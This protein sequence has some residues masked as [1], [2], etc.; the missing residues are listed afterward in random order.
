MN[1]KHFSLVSAD[2]DVGNELELLRNILL[3]QVENTY[4]FLKRLPAPTVYALVRSSLRCSSPDGWR[5][6]VNNPHYLFVRWK[7][8]CISPLEYPILD[9]IDPKFFILILKSLPFDTIYESITSDGNTL[10]TEQKGRELSLSISR[11][12]KNYPGLFYGLNPFIETLLFQI[13]N[14]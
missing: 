1:L 5:P 8:L 2:I 12:F 14:C 7:L 9:S 10:F 11:L 3:G 6:T 13:G 4:L